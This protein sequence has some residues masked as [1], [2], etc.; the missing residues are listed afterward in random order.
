MNCIAI[1]PHSN[2]NPSHCR[3][4]KI[5]D[6]GLRRFEG[7]HKVGEHKVRPYGGLC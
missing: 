4:L 3:V 2:R 5:A 7:E 6:P 1:Y